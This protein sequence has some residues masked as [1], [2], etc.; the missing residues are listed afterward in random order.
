MILG[1]RNL[2]H[3]TEKKN[4]K[5]EI[6]KE[7]ITKKLDSYQR[8]IAYWRMYPDK[9]IDYLCSLN[10]DNK[11]KFYFIQRIFLRIACRYR[12]TYA[13][14]SR[15]FSKSFLSVL[16]LMIKAILYPGAKL[17]TVAE[18]KSQSASILAAKIEEICGLIPALAA[19]VIWDTRGKIA[20]T[21]QSK[22]SVEYSFKNGS[23]ISN[24]SMSAN[25]RGMRAQGV[26]TEEVATIKDQSKYEEIIAPMLVVSRKI[27][28]QTDPDEV[29]N[30]NAVYITSAGFKGTY[31]YDKLIDI[32]CHM[33]ADKKYEAFILG[34]DWRIPVVEGLQ[35]ANFIQNQETG[36]AM[37]EAGFEREYGSIWSGTIEGAFFDMN[38]F[39]KHRI[40]NIAETSYNNGISK[41][42]GGGYYV[43]GVDVGRSGCTT[44]IVIIK[45]TPAKTNGVN[46]KQVV[47][48]YTMEDEHFEK[49][50]ITIKRLFNQYKC[51]MCVVDANGLGI[52][53]VD[54]LIQDQIDPDTDEILFNFGIANLDNIT[55]EDMRK[56]YKSFET[57]D[58]IKNAMW[59][60]KANAPLNTEMYSY[61]ENQLRNG[62]LKFLID[63]STAK[64]KLLAQ[65]QGQKMTQT[66]RLEYLRPYT[67]TDI[68]KTQMANLTQENEGA[69]I[70][71][72]QSNRKILKDKFSAL[73]YGL[74]WCKIQE[75]RRH[76]RKGRNL[77]DFMFFTKK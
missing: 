7:K 58:T 54:Y 76:K 45:S 34:G 6:D 5:V 35:P 72:K 14:F 20:K 43:M 55:S 16:A 37:D 26:L 51:S 41:R 39:D 17:I 3:I 68:L 28:G 31:A 64:N 1:L 38:K 32:L 44:E 2:L 48:L 53:L 77:K 52:G 73:I 33:V 22:D 66:E 67:E 42:D 21:T 11:F 25:S 30:Q 74:Y 46:V 60:M 61:C 19:E 65:A 50:A 69:N 27:N 71:L 36:T 62:K 70:I 13:V 49:Q 10:P 23:K 47:N 18:G 63:A 8:L 24:V 75:D 29:L 4:K 59:L 12:N 57:E 56:N 9:F 40:L 15:G